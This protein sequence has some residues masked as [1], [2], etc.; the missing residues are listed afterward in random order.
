MDNEET[1]LGGMPDQA[2]EAPSEQSYS[3]AELKENALAIFGVQPEVIA[4]ALH[5]NDGDEF[6]VTEMKKLINSFL[7]RKVK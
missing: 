4:G 7:K 6:T 3:L 1:A 5:G 2:A